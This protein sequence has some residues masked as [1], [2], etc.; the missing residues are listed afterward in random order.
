M[1]GFS[2]PPHHPAT[3]EFSV[4]KNNFHLFKV[5]WSSDTGVQVLLSLKHKYMLVIKYTYYNN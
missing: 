1:R 2:S 3:S 4:P 5:T